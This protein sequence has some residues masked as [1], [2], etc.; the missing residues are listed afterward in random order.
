MLCVVPTRCR[1]ECSPCVFW[2]FFY[3]SSKPYQ[4]VIMVCF[5]RL[6]P[7]YSFH[8]RLEVSVFKEAEEAF[9]AA[10]DVSSAEH[11]GSFRTGIQSARSRQRVHVSAA[12]TDPI[13]KSSQSGTCLSRHSARRRWPESRSKRCE[14]DPGSR[15]NWGRGRAGPVPNETC[16]APFTNRRGPKCHTFDHLSWLIS[17]ARY[18]PVARVNSP[19]SRRYAGNRAFQHFLKGQPS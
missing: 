1:C 13:Q 7:V 14:D 6:Q 3:K 8:S 16:L 11:A 18:S 2:L 12:K 4:C 19:Q 5:L 9:R 17:S 10:S 15:P